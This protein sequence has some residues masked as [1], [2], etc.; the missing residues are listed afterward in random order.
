MTI[1]ICWGLLVLLAHI[2]SAVEC[3]SH[4]AGRVGDF[5]KRCTGMHIDTD[6]RL[7][8]YQAGG[9]VDYTSIT[10]STGLPLVLNLHASTC[11]AELQPSMQHASASAR[12][13][14][15]GLQRM[16]QNWRL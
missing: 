6:H 16:L 11:K 1:S 9:P 10:A 15:C 5:N 14:S 7:L 3:I 8:C 2:L 13:L 12:L 4:G